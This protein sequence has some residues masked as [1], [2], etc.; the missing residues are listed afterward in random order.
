MSLRRK[1]FPTYN[2]MEF[3]EETF[4]WMELLFQEEHHEWSDWDEYGWGIMWWD[5][6]GGGVVQSMDELNQMRLMTL[7]RSLNIKTA[8]KI[9][10]ERGW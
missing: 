5:Y 3:K 4:Y 9:A 6:D 1:K 10:N 8:R 2:R 7:L